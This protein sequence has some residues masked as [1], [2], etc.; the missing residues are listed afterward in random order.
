MDNSLSTKVS[1]SILAACGVA[2]LTYYFYKKRQIANLLAYIKSIDSYNSN[3]SKISKVTQ[4]S[5][6]KDVAKIVEL[7]EKF[8]LLA[9]DSEWVQP[10]GT[11]HIALLQI[12]FPNGQ[13]FLI[14]FRQDLPK[15]FL[16]ILEN[17]DILKVGI[18]ILDEDIKRFRLQWQIEPR[19]LVELK[20]LV[21][22]YHPKVDKLGAKNL[23]SRFLNVQLDK[24]WKISASN[25]EADKLTERQIKYASND[26]LTAMAIA[27]KIIQEHYES[28]DIDNL[29]QKS[30][31]ICSL[32]KDIPFTKKYKPPKNGKNLPQNMPQKA[33]KI[34]QHH[35]HSTLKRPLYDN[36]KLEA[37]DGQL[38]C[39]CDSR[40]ALW[41]VSKNLGH[42]VSQGPEENDLTVRLN[43]EPSGR[44][45]GEY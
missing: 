20:Y 24:H 27:L 25:W 10:N 14:D 2:T 33:Q 12:S 6:K 34:K 4:V 28:S 41:Y 29:I 35:G 7:A 32:F 39:V 42:V 30:Y 44:P 31:Q 45:K 9:I 13:C 21:K 38:L 19:G 16:D 37:P 3:G 15:A 8:K 26:V 23:A 11:V 17:S 18:G 1:I 36:A 40:K 5:S 22:K 43:F